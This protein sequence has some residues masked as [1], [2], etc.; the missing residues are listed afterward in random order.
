MILSLLGDEC[1]LC[2]IDYLSIFLLV[3]YYVY[4]KNSIFFKKDGKYNDF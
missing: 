1:L 2:C 4:M 3:L